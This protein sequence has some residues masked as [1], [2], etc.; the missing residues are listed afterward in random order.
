LGVVSQTQS[1]E[2]LQKARDLKIEK[3]GD[4]EGWRYF[5]CGWWFCYFNR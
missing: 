4:Q 2:L 3:V 5:T 1:D